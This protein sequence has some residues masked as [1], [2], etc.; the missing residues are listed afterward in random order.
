MQQHLSRRLVRT[1]QQNGRYSLHT[2]PQLR[3][4]AWREGGVLCCASADM[5]SRGRI[6]PH[7][8]SSLRAH[9]QPH[10][11]ASTTRLPFT[12]M[13]GYADIFGFFINAA[14]FAPRL[15]LGVGG[16][17]A[18]AFRALSSPRR[19]CYFCFCTASR[20]LALYFLAAKRGWLGRSNDAERD[21]GER[22]LVNRRLGSRHF[23]GR[24][25][26]GAISGNIFP[27]LLAYRAAACL[28]QN[29]RRR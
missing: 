2:A 12:A 9:L 28:L 24:E 15:P 27:L 23:S 8:G 18:G 26:A 10:G 22:A 20:T 3:C 17:T 19:S 4:R 25:I 29:R 1:S 7:L 13:P 11:A 6:S 14:R 5:D 21:S 16:R